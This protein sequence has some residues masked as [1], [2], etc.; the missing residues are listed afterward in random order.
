M[1]TVQLPHGDTGRVEGLVRAQV[2]TASIYDHETEGVSV[3]VM[4]VAV[5]LLMTLA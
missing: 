5:W 2:D 4:K 3:L 1:C